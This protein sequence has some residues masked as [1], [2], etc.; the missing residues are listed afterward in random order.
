MEIDHLSNMASKNTLINKDESEDKLLQIFEPNVQSD[1]VYKFINGEISFN[2]YLSQM[3]DIVEDDTSECRIVETDDDRMSIGTVDDLCDLSEDSDLNISEVESESENL[4]YKK[5]SKKLIKKK[6]T[7]RSKLSPTLRAVMG[8]ANVCYAKGDTQTAVKMCLE[9]IKEEPNASEPLKTLASIY[10]EMGQQDKSLQMR[11]IAAHIGPTN[12]DEWIE[13]ARILKKNNQHRQA[14]ACLTRA[15]NLD[16]LNLSLYEERAAILKDFGIGG[17]EGYGYL[18]LLYKLNPE[19]DGKTLIYLCE[20]VAR[21]YYNEKKFEKAC[22]M[23]KYAFEKCSGLITNA[24]VNL[25]LDVLITTKKFKECLEILIK[26]C[27]LSIEITSNDNSLIIEKCLIPEDIPID[28]REKLIICLIHFNCVDIVRIQIEILLKEDPDITGDLFF[29]VGTMLIEKE[30]YEDA[31]K[32][33]IPLTKTDSFNSTMLWFKLALCYKQLNKIEECHKIYQEAIEYFPN[34]IELKLKFCDE[35]KDAKLYKEAIRI[36][37]ID[38]RK[39]N[40]FIYERCKLYLLLN[41]TNNFIETALQLFRLHYKEISCSEDFTLFSSIFRLSKGMKEKLSQFVPSVVDNLVTLDQEWDIF[42]KLCNLYVEKKEYDLLQRLTLSLYLSFKFISKRKELRAA[43]MVACILN[44]DFELGFD[45][46]R[47]LI[48][49]QKENPYR[50]WNTFCLSTLRSEYNRVHKF[51]IRFLLRN[52]HEE[53]GVMLF[54]N[55]CL[56][57]GTYKYALNDYS[58]LYDKH[59]TPIL[60]LLISLNMLHI[61][62]QKFTTSKHALVTQMVTFLTKYQELRGSDANQE[63][64]YN[65]GRAF[66]QLELLPQAIFYYK[67]ALNCNTPVKGKMFNLQ[68]DIAFNLHLIYLNS[69]QPVI[70][71]NYLQKY[72]IM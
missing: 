49:Q 25:Y 37:L 19:K 60:A 6:R 27:N 24:E 70:A 32:L 12:K 36:T 43:M 44:N 10:E 17:V 18:R 13:L 50:V 4:N 40:L 8:Q 65:I 67:E 38:D 64:F 66:H 15:I 23:L 5:K 45:L 56:F 33:L 62:C 48:L 7:H 3:E 21:L 41:D 55:S 46:A 57:A 69:G 16:V 34:D 51:L 2:E 29:D 28:I 14:V 42:L 68:C 35:L 53:N 58:L 11:L 30:L 72:I 63:I 39:L 61:T 26:F 52:P 54:A 22:N 9:I 71:N 47:F 59:K 31:I 1:A 20:K